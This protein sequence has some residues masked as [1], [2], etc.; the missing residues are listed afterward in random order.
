MTRALQAADSSKNAVRLAV[1]LSGV[2]SE[3]EELRRT[4]VTAQAERDDLA[5]LVDR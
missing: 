3:K 5:N 2:K 1:E 4:V